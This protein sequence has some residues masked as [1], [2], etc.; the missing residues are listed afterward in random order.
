MKIVI[1][2]DELRS[3][4]QMY[5]TLSNRHNVEVAQD[6]DDL[7]Q[8][9]EQESTDFTFLGLD[10]KSIPKANEKAFEIASRIQAKHPKIKVVGICDRKTQVLQKKAAYHGINR[11]IT[12]PIKNRELLAALENIA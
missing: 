7:M 6:V 8:L 10:D 12:R 9:L 1:F 2:N 4:M 3:E 11:V 5:L